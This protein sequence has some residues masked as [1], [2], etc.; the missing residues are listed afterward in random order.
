MELKKRNAI[1]PIKRVLMKNYIL[2]YSSNKCSIQGIYKGPL[3][4]RVVVGFV[5]TSDYDGDIKTNPFNFQNFGIKQLTLKVSSR[6]MPY[7]SGLSL[8][9]EK[10]QY[11]QGYSTLFSDIDEKPNHILP[12]DYKNV[13]TL[14]AFDLTPDLCNNEKFNQIKEG[15]LDLDIELKADN[16]SITGIFYLEFDNKIEVTKHRNISFDYQI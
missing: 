2:P 12:T 10:N 5:K 3:P 15:S 13:Y 9:F 14:F 11:L 7:S 6:A 1:Y 8:D 16:V 4:N